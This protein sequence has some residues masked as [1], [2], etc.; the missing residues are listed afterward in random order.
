MPMNRPAGQPS[1]LNNVRLWELVENAKTSLWHC[2]LVAA[3]LGRS[4]YEVVMSFPNVTKPMQK[5]FK[6]PPCKQHLACGKYYYACKQCNEQVLNTH[7][8]DLNM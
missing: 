2:L 7:C 8:S 1:L 5:C 4:N 3:F 6:I